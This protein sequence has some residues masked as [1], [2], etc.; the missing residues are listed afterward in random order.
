MKKKRISC[1]SIDFRVAD[2]AMLHNG[3]AF[4]W[5]VTTCLNV[6][7]W[8][9]S[10][11]WVCGFQHSAMNNA[12]AIFLKLLFRPAT[13]LQCRF[14]STHLY[15]F[16]I[17]STFYR[18]NVIKNVHVKDNQCYCPLESGRLLAHPFL[19]H[20]TLAY[21]RSLV[22]SLFSATNWTYTQQ[23]PMPTLCQYKGE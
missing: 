4:Q 2:H 23:P 18:Y 3:D 12:Y 7:V 6:C 8:K 21:E 5:P 1:G 13:I 22:Y 9:G 15:I 11:C 19:F 20:L 14:F 16:F 17:F 10:S